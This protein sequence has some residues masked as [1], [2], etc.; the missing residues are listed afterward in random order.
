MR[1]VPS[2]L[3]AT[4]ALAVLG[5]GS[6]AVGVRPLR[7]ADLVVGGESNFP[8]P[9]IGGDLNGDGRDDVVI[10]TRDGLVVVLGR[11]RF[12]RRARVGALGGTF[13]IRVRAHPVLPQCCHAAPDEILTPA[14]AL[15]DLDGDGLDELGIGGL[16]YDGELARVYGSGTTPTATAYVLFGDR[17][18][19]FVDLSRDRSRVAAITTG[20]RSDQSATVALQR[21][22]DGR[23]LAVANQQSSYPDGCGVGMH[24]LPVR[25]RPLTAILPRVRRGERIDLAAGGSAVHRLRAAVHGGVVTGAAALGRQLSVTGDLPLQRGTCVVTR[26]FARIGSPAEFERGGRG[27]RAPRDLREVAQAGGDFDGDGR[28]DLAGA[29]LRGGEAWVTVYT[30]RRPPARLGPWAAEE[31]APSVRFVGDV[32]RDGRDDLL[33]TND[34]QVTVVS[35]AAHPGRDV[36]PCR[37]V[38]SRDVGRDTDSVAGDVDGDGTPDLVLTRSLTGSGARIIFGPIDPAGRLRPERVVRRAAARY[39]ARNLVAG[40]ASC[41][42]A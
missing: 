9:V 20:L 38:V 21:L 1:R 34:F 25:I 32:N 23:L 16:G 40:N 39:A 24:P 33:V 15:G 8:E 3:V 7:T 22:T 41:S 29:L 5:C 37:T 11:R 6:P 36:T 27:A 30:G 18:T 2:V 42:D 31:D 12:P 17:A 35:G 10:P 26:H 19:G 4:A 14:T 28:T 13:A